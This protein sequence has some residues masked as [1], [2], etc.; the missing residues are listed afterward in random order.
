MTQDMC[1]LVGTIGPGSLHVRRWFRS[2][3]RE[4]IGSLGACDVDGGE[5][6]LAYVPGQAQCTPFEIMAEM[7]LSDVPVG[8]ADAVE[9]EPSEEGVA[10]EEPEA[11]AEVEVVEVEVDS[12]ASFRSVGLA[13]ALAI[14]YPI[15]A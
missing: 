2:Y 14:A 8:D 5:I 9:Q 11:E 1:A 10:V 7:Q 3:F 15:I 6:D 4:P 13:A 12:P